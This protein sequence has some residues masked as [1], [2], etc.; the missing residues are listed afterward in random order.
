MSD[1]SV[2]IPSESEDEIDKGLMHEIQVTLKAELLRYKLPGKHYSISRQ[3]TNSSLRSRPRK[4]RDKAEL[5]LKHM[6]T[7]DRI[8]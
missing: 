4:I 7:L 2:S 5:M 8:P 1:S 6:T 3:P